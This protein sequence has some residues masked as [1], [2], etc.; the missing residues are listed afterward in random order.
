MAKSIFGLFNTDAKDD[1]LASVTTVAEWAATLP[2]NDPVAAATSMVH[3]LEGMC[4]AKPALTL[5]RT[6]ALMEL[7]RLSLPLQAQLQTQHRTAALSEDVRQDLWL[8]RNDLTRWLAYA[9]ERIYDGTTSQPVDGWLRGHLHGVFSRMFHYRARQAQLGFLRYEQ[10]IPARWKFLHAAYKVASG[11]GVS[12]LPFSLNP[13]SQPTDR[14]SVEQEYLWLLLLQRINSGN[15]SVPQ[16]ELASQWARELVPSLQL[17]RTPPK[18]GPYWLL[19]LASTEGLTT[20]PLEL[21]EGDLLFLDIA[22]MRVHLNALTETLGKQLGPDSEIT[23]RAETR[24]RLALIKRLEVLLLPN[25]KPQPRRGERRSEQKAVLVASSWAEIPVLM[26]QSHPWKKHEPLKY[27]YDGLAG[28][29]G[30]T[31][32]EVPT[33]SIT[34]NDSLFPEQR[35]WQVLDVSESGCRIESRTRQASQLLVGGLLV[36]LFEGE[37]RRRVGIVRRLKRRTADH[38]EIGVEIITENAVLVRPEPI[39]ADGEALNTSGSD[40]GGAFHALYVPP[41]ERQRLTPVR[42]VFVP[43]A[44]FLPNGHYSMDVDG[45]TNRIRLVLIIEQTK[46]W[47]WSTFE[48]VGAWR[49]RPRV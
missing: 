36:V 32:A 21:P 14:F 47:V 5:E 8:G 18:S 49:E 42:S 6:L 40:K 17:T 38:T 9:Y 3:L 15:L 27:T 30:V 33:T 34:V 4:A 35:G 13:N 31:A 22:P 46:D 28:P 10:W 19:D 39:A 1:P 12:S 23:G 43:A 48:A 41:Q 24:A 25:A 29:A 2:T 11:Q 44:E 20:A 16:I 37:T 7:D 26:R 45:Q